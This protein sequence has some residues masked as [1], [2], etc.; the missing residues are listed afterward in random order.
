MNYYKTALSTNRQTF[1]N[2]QEYFS[3]E[4]DVAIVNFKR[5]YDLLYW[6]LEALYAIEKDFNKN[7]EIVYGS[8]EELKSLFNAPNIDT[9][10]T[11]KFQRIEANVD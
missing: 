5:S 2:A 8:I 1:L 3:G 10:K 9:M 11:A 6:N 7:R 4:G